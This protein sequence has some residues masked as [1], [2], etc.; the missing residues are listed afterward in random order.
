M[1][2]LV[3]SSSSSS[4]PCHHQNDETSLRNVR[5][6]SPSLHGSPPSQLKGST[7][8]SWSVKGWLLQSQMDVWTYMKTIQVSQCPPKHL[9]HRQHI[10]STPQWQGWSSLP[11]DHRLHNDDK[12]TCTASYM[13]AFEV[14][15]GWNLP[16][17][18]GAHVCVDWSNIG[19][20][21]QTCLEIL[22][23]RVELARSLGQPAENQWCLHS[24]F[25]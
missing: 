11:L 12:V 24:R 3:Q 7:S 14:K 16:W 9:Q 22:S 25:K 1:L 5:R 8:S 13:R 17:P 2:H 15:S 18:L 20:I 6:S 10:F 21:D 23:N 19:Q 4:P